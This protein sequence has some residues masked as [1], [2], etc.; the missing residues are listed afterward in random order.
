M[1]GG[2]PLPRVFEDA[3]RCARATYACFWSSG[4]SHVS[5]CRRRPPAAPEHLGGQAARTCPQRQCAQ[6]A[7]PVRGQPA[8][9]SAVTAPPGIDEPEPGEPNGEVVQSARRCARRPRLLERAS[10]DIWR[11]T[12]PDDHPIAISP[13][14]RRAQPCAA[15]KLIFAAVVVTGPPSRSSGPPLSRTRGGNAR[16]L[17][18]AARCASGATGSPG[19]AHLYRGADAN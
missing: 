12:Q 17:A 4:T 16:G 15:T 5:T 18:L 10:D 3:R 6:C 1:P 7:T 9:C 11:D 19:G 13:A 2:E 14:R 8:P